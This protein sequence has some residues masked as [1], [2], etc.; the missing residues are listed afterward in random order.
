MSQ[1]TCL[2]FISSV[3]AVGVGWILALPAHGAEV[4]TRAEEPFAFLAERHPQTTDTNGPYR[5]HL[6][7]VL[8][9]E[10]NGGA[11]LYS[12]VS[13]ATGAQTSQ[14]QV[15]LQR[16]EQGKGWIGQIP[17][18]PWDT[19]IQYHFVLTN[20]KGA[21]LRHPARPPGRYAFQVVPLE[22]LG[23]SLSGGATAA[24]ARQR[25]RLH[26]PGLVLRLRSPARPSG[27]LV[28][29]P[30]S[31]TGVPQERR[32]SLIARPLEGPD[33][34]QGPRDEIPSTVSRHPSSGTLHHGRPSEWVLTGEVPDLQP[35]EVGDFFI[36]VS[37]AAGQM[38]TIPAGAP[39]QVYSIKRSLRQ[40]QSV[41]SGSL[42]VTGL[43]AAD[44]ARWVGIQNGGLWLSGTDPPP[45]HWGLAQ[46]LPSAAAQFVVS[47]PHSLL[48]Y[49]GTD[50]GVFT[51]EGDGDLPLMLAG[52][53][54]PLPGSGLPG[55]DA[56]A[57]G[58]RA[59]PAALSTVDGTLLFQLQREPE[60]EQAQGATKLLE[61][62]DGQLREWRPGVPVASLSTAMFDGVD[63]CWLLGAFIVRQDSSLQPALL[64][65]C[66]DQTDVL[67]LPV[68]LIGADR[69]LPQRILAITRD[70]DANALALAV[71]YLR[72]GDASRRSGYCVLRLEEFSG[73]LTVRAQELGDLGVEITSLATDWTRRR[74]LVG[75]R[76][77][78]ILAVR[79]TTVEPL[80]LAR[81]L[82]R[83]ITVL[84]AN[85]A[86]DTVLIGTTEG[87]FE[88]NDSDVKPIRLPDE[89]RLPADSQP[90]DL[91]PQQQPSARSE[92][93]LVS[94]YREGLAELE[95]GRDGR[96]RPVQRLRPGRE[97]PEGLFGETK[98][99][100]DGEI[101]TIVHSQGL[102]RVQTNLHTTL[103]RTNDGLF[104]AHLLQ[105]LVRH[106]GEVW[107]AHTPF[108]FGPNPG[109]ALQ[110]LRGNE[111][112]RTALLPNR[113]LATISQWLEVPE[114]G[115]VFAATRSGVAEIGDDGAISVLASDSVSAIARDSRTMVLGAAGTTFLRW[116]GAKFSP[117][118]FQVNHPRWPVGRFYPGVPLDLAIDNQGLW[119]LLFHGGNLALLDAQGNY[120]GL[121]DAE[122]GVP[123]TARRLALAPNTGEIFI[124]SIEGL[125]VLE[126]V[127]APRRP[128]TK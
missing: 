41:A 14:G 105:L 107:V 122:D 110:M 4:T 29:R 26:T 63:G 108:P 6:R 9:S 5:I 66:G 119:Y 49:V 94:S 1:L 111:I 69:A 47:E 37:T 117:V 113:D 99:T 52:P 7:Q 18:Q 36:E 71:E 98:Y 95:R 40:V 125:V 30:L 89:E 59:G 77:R 61:W 102:L 88:L 72:A 57:W 100:P 16:A 20:K 76:G 55:A 123:A 90:M 64:R 84:K 92:R 118:L 73:R 83:E 93:L 78:G 19:T 27:T 10:V 8:G 28:W 24:A 120:L 12:A 65:R 128:G 127:V 35:G 58:Y 116:D 91:H 85:G 3:F 112:T 44:N 109:G 38:R 46:G 79:G 11:L 32:L 104:S 126:P 75:T 62:R 34:G 114:R 115:T 53:Y 15:P 42:F 33:A 48:A 121:L 124:G 2:P 80:A 54:R 25:I 56:A 23:V 87:A 45:R 31:S 96:W 101:L 82:P 68:F 103:L 17:G 43:D 70:P 106:S 13:G 74:I 86:T 67:A 60:F 21:A 50:Q 81:S 51:I 39:T 22:S 97:L